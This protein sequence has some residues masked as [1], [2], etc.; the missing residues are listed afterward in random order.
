MTLNYKEFIIWYTTF[1]SF[2]KIKKAKYEKNQKILIIHQFIKFFKVK[3]FID[4]IIY[5]YYNLYPYMIDL[6]FLRYALT[7]F[8]TDI[9]WFVIYSPRGETHCVW[10]PPNSAR[11]CFEPT[12]THRVHF[13]LFGYNIT[14]DCK[15]YIVYYIIL[16]RAPSVTAKVR[17]WR[18]DRY[19][20]ARLQLAQHHT[21]YYINNWQVWL[22]NFHVFNLKTRCI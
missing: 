19:I 1:K 15:V 13:D 7:I 20:V 6:L 4:D 5:Y 17:V 3:L 9:I 16:I 2:E 18:A 14:V 21:G 22:T 8:W 12:Y 10:R 11:H